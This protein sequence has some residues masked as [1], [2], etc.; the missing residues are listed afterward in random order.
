MSS[1]R[2]ERHLRLYP[3]HILFKAWH[4]AQRVT[5]ARQARE[6]EQLPLTF[7]PSALPAEPDRADDASAF[8]SA[9]RPG[10][11]RVL[12]PVTI[13][14]VYA[15]I[16]QELERKPEGALDRFPVR[17]LLSAL[18]ANLARTVHE[19]LPGAHSLDALWRSC[20]GPQRLF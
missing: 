15:F 14:E 6:T 19:P 9:E 1:D 13:D 17:V 12:R 2:L 7:P 3:D 10:E 4:Q 16:R 8:Q 18:W 5:S 11:Y 20:C